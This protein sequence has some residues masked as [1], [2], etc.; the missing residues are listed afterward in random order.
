MYGRSSRRCSE[1]VSRRSK[2]LE[3]SSA[4]TSSRIAIAD[5]IGERIARLDWNRIERDL[6]ARGYAV[7][8][9]ILRARECA[10]L[11]ALYPDRERFRSRIVME[12]LRYGVGEYKYFARPMPEIVEQLRTELY[13]R[14][15]ATAHRW[16]ERLGGRYP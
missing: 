7:T 6:D 3:N 11:I 2:K 8:G 9:K 10:G 16:A 1:R 4:P 13:G 15:V 12:R 5:T 14:L